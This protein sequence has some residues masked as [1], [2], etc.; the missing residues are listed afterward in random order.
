MTAIWARNL[1]L[2]QELDIFVSDLLK[3]R[4][5]L[6]DTESAKEVRKRNYQKRLVVKDSL[7][8]LFYTRFFD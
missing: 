4:T 2:L 7:E 1:L 5:A 3:V 6:A 8:A